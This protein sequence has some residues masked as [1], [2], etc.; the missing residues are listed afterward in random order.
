V[1]TPSGIRVGSTVAELRRTYGSRLTSAPAKYVPGGRDYFL[2]R[3]QAPHW[4]IRFVASP[5][6]KITQIAFG[7]RAVGYVEACG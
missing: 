1:R 3:A 5:R 2:R 6:G 4:R 7:A